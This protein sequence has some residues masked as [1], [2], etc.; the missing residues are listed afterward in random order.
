MFEEE[1]KFYPIIPVSMDYIM[2]S[3][4]L[5]RYV[6]ENGYWSSGVAGDENYIWTGDNYYLLNI[7]VRD[8]LE[9]RNIDFHDRKNFYISENNRVGL[10]INGKIM[11]V[12][13]IVEDHRFIENWFLKTYPHNSLFYVTLIMGY[14]LMDILTGYQNGLDSHLV[15]ASVLEYLDPER[16]LKTEAFVKDERVQQWLQSKLK[17]SGIWVDEKNFKPVRPLGGPLDFGVSIDKMVSDV[18]RD[19]VDERYIGVDLCEEGEE[20]R[21]EIYEKAMDVIKRLMLRDEMAE[22]LE[23]DDDDI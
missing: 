2:Y 4:R 23:Y 10:K 5:I 12:S 11:D 21:D 17:H 16:A 7:P 20:I 3:T 13:E 6:L 15:N 9:L 18:L 22:E 1:E 14:G 19:A 8:F